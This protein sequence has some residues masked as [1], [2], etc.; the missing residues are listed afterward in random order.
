MAVPTYDGL[1]APTVQ[2][3]KQLGG[4][5]SVDELEEVVA[6]NLNLSEKDVNDIHRGNITKLSYRMAWARTYLK[7]YGVLENSSRGVW[8]LTSEGRRI[9]RVDSK[10][11]VRRVKEV[12]KKRSDVEDEDSD[13]GADIVGEV[14]WKD[15]LLEVLKSVSPGAFE[16]LCKRLLRESGFVNV[17]VTG[18]SGDGGIDGK[19]VVKLGNLLSFHVAFQAKRWKDVV[20][21]SVIRDFRGAMQGRADRGIVITTGVFTRDA[22]NE[23][24]RDGAIPVDLVDGEEL[25]E[26]LKNLSLGVD[27]KKEVVERVTV[28]K[29]WFE[30]L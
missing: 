14:N 2:A 28:N 29:D 21:P 27:V 26:R 30:T 5:A 10:E 19:G 1:I 15:G 6:R 4:S 13:L 25:A 24:Q 9:E 22:R 18:K 8:A 17:E 16:N 23:A 7:N 11:V 20:G 12:Q 3:M